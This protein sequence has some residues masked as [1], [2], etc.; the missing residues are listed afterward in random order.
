MS[1]DPAIARLAEKQMSTS[2][3]L[4]KIHAALSENRPDAALA[5]FEKAIDAGVGQQVAYGLTGTSAPM[6]GES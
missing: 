2:V 5:L 1:Q 3:L 6:R 4:E